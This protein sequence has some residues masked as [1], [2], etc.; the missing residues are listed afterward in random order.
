MA[1]AQILPNT[2]LLQTPHSC[3]NCVGENTVG[4]IQS[5]N[6][7]FG[8]HLQR[9]FEQ[10]SNSGDGKILPV[11]GNNLPPTI[12]GSKFN[13]LKFKLSKLFN[14][15]QTIDIQNNILGQIS[16][17]A[18]DE[19]AKSKI[20]IN[21]T[22][23]S[24]LT[25]QLNQ[26]LRDGLT[27]E[28]S[29]EQLDIPVLSKQIQDEVSSDQNNLFGL[30]NSLISELSTKPV[31]NSK[32][33]PIS[34]QVSGTNFISSAA[35]ILDF[36]QNLTNEKQINIAETL[37]RLNA[38]T[39]VEVENSVIPAGAQKLEK[40]DNKPAN[41]YEFTN[42]TLSEEGL[43]KDVA[44]NLTKSLDFIQQHLN[45]IRS[46]TV[47]QNTNLNQVIDTYSNLITTGS[48]NKVIEAPIPLLIKQDA[49][50]AQAQQSVDQSITQNIKWLLG[51]KV[52]NAKINVYPESLGQVNIALNLEDSNLKVNFVATSIVTK[53]LIESTASSLRNHFNESGINLQEVNVETRFSNQAEKNSQFSDLNDQDTN[54]FTATPELTSLG[55]ET[56]S[57]H[58]TADSSIP[59]YLI[60]AYA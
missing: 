9:S 42:N 50:I 44:K 47:H 2:N 8:S 53:E 14:D 21:L 6:G 28:E 24:E 18:L 41:L 37:P 7:S 51:N 36:Q 4:Q 29:L 27:F 43:F 38:D 40:A 26:L 22:G 25:E 1:E 17:G 55:D 45:P 15:I 35:N 5:V 16:N 48:Q 3:S 58:E 19:A 49:N 23:L 30:V 31:T 11:T 52:Q 46:D 13:D 57:W 34:A 12:S 20:E 39:A 54:K 59:R 32:S 33:Q 60:D 10:S 56:S